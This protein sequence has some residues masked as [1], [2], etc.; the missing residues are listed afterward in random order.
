M[1][2]EDSPKANSANE[3]EIFSEVEGVQQQYPGKPVHR[4]RLFPNGT[5]TKQL[6]TAMQASKPLLPVGGRLKYFVNEWYKFTSNP[7]ILDTVKAC[8][9]TLTAF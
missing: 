3:G 9:L 2:K 6:S 4:E 5:C 8:T 1:V 7:S